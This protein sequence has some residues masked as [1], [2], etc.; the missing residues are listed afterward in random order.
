MN[1]Y[2]A[3]DRIV[4]VIHADPDPAIVVNRGTESG[5]DVG[6]VFVGQLGDETVP[7]MDLATHCEK[8][9]IN[10]Y[11]YLA[12]DLERVELDE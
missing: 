6:V 11:S 10:C 5:E 2:V 12:S 9:K 3:G 7:P 4:K 1:P 8:H